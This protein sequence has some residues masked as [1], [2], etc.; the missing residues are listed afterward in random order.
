MGA[1]PRRGGKITGRGEAP[2]CVVHGDGN[3]DGVT[4]NKTQILCHPVGVLYLLVA[5]SA[6]VPLR[7]TTCLW[8]VVPSGHFPHRFPFAPS[9]H[10]IP[11]YHT[12][13]SHSPLKLQISC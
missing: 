6:G 5:S 13:M 2:A 11:H 1:K 4:D 10:F 9:G 7:S 3:P 12:F 8:S